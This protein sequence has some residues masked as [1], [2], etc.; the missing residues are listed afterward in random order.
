M[1]RASVS[2]VVPGVLDT[3][4]YAADAATVDTRT[5]RILGA[6]SPLLSAWIESPPNEFHAP[7]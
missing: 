3:S 6:A 5:L 7:T 4:T 2:C 1:R